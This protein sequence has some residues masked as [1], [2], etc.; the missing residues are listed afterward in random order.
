VKILIRKEVYEEILTHM[1]YPPMIKFN[2]CKFII[3]HKERKEINYDPRPTEV[4]VNT[5]LLLRLFILLGV[6]LV[7][8]FAAQVSSSRLAE[9]TAAGEDAALLEISSHDWFARNLGSLERKVDLGHDWFARNMGNYERKVDLGHDWFARNIG[10]YERKVDL[11]HDWFARNI[12]SF[13]P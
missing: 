13:E 1:R 6:L 3:Y 5:K 9:G 4:T 2:E 12:G 8:F 7:I 10:N 11:G